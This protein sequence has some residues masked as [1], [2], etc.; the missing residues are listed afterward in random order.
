MPQPP[1]NTPRR[2]DWFVINT[3]G[4]QSLIAGLFSA[5]FG[6]AIDKPKEY[7][8]HWEGFAKRYGMRLTG[9]ATQNAT[10]AGL[11]ALWGEDPRYFR[12]PDASFGRRVGH[13]IKLTFVARRRNGNF[14]PAYARFIAIPSANFLSNTWR[15]DGEATN[16]NA[17]GRTV[18]GFAGRMAGNA[19][20]E[21]W[22]DLTHRIFHR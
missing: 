14:A 11:G 1:I 21:F 5:G 22:P 12:A 16:G 6:T 4:P 9:I 17:I 8:P 3:I 2:F 7:G 18:L 10:E 13:V 20:M 19:F 15:A